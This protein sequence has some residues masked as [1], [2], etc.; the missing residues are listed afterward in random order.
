MVGLWWC[1]QK[2]LERWV[3][4]VLVVRWLAGGNRGTLTMQKTED[5]CGF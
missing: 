5:F 4:V 3:E 2:V 1:V